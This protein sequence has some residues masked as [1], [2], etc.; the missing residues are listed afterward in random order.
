MKLLVTG[1]LGFIGINF[2][3]YWLNRHGDHIINL[4]KITYASN[5][6]KMIESP[7]HG[8]Y[9]FVKGDICDE[10]LVDELVSNVDCVVN[11]AAESHVDNSI[12]NS[13]VFVKTNVLGTH[14]ILEAVRKY[15]TR[16]H[17]ISTDEVFGSLSSSKEEQF[18][19][20]TCYNPSNPY[21]ATKAS[22]D[23]LVNAYRNTY[24]IESTIS[25]CSNNFGPFQ[26]P[27][28]LIPKTINLILKGKKAK[29]YGNGSQIRDWIYVEDHCEAIDLILKKGKIGKSYLVGSRNE[30]T[31]LEVV[32][33]IIELIGQSPVD[34]I[35]FVEDRLGHDVRYSIDPTT[36]ERELGWKA[37]KNFHDAL[38]ETVDFY[39]NN[40]SFLNKR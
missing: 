28:K 19:D 3:N 7:K 40:K 39:R 1:G 5:N 20:S 27:E 15:D 6:P 24:G 11:F 14:N 38:S 10:T 30:R 4:D 29:I 22:A 26:H 9:E 31:N 13:S 21:S 23:H 18:N 34:Y 2:I 12:E 32:S 25:N 33:E 8:S 36:I 17:H 37:K 35:E 16:F